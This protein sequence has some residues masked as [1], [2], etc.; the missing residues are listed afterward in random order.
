MTPEEHLLAAADDMAEH[1]HCKEYYF[2]DPVNWQTSSSCAYGSLARTVSREAEEGR[3]AAITEAQECG[4]AKML[5]AHI[6][7]KFPHLRGEETWVTITSFNDLPSTTGE[8]VILAM[9]EAAHG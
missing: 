4:A 8:D 5:A 2:D 3:Y 6:Q 9:K 1:G 7:D